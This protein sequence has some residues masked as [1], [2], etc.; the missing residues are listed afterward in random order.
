MSKQSEGQDSYVPLDGEEAKPAKPASDYQEIVRNVRDFQSKA[1]ATYTVWEACSRI[2]NGEKAA[3]ST[4]SQVNYNVA[5]PT[6]PTSAQQ[7]MFNKLLE[8]FRTLHAKLGVN[9][10]YAGAMPATDAPDDVA[11]AQAAEALL[12]Y[13]MQQQKFDRKLNTGLAWLL[14]TGNVGL[15]LCQYGTETRLEIV[16]PF[17][18]FY[19]SNLS[20]PDDTRW[21]VIRRFAT[22]RELIEMFPQHKAQIIDIPVSIDPIAMPAG[23]SYPST[24]YANN[25]PGDRI[26]YWEYIG[27]DGE[28]CYLLP[29][30]CLVLFQST[31]PDDCWPFA[32]IRYTAI[33]GRMWG[34][35]VIEPSIEPQ[36]FYNL[37]RT[38]TLRNATLCGNP[39][40][41]VH[42][43]DAQT[44]SDWTDRPG[45]VIRWGGDADLAVPAPAYLTP[46]SIPA[47][48]QNLPTEMMSE[49]LDAMGVHAT[50]L[51]KRQAGMTSGRAIEALTENDASQLA[52][53]MQNIE[54]AVQHIGHCALVMMKAYMPEKTMIR[55][56][57]RW[58]APVFKE[59]K[60][61]DLGEET[62]EIFIDADTLFRTRV[63]DR[64]AQVLQDMQMGLVSPEEA[65]DM[66]RARVARMPDLTYMGDLRHA[67][68][69]LESVVALKAPA[70]FY[71]KDNLQLMERVFGEFMKSP[72]YYQLDP[73]TQQLVSDQ[74]DSITA[75]MNPSAQ[76][77][78][79]FPRGS[80]AEPATAIAPDPELVETEGAVDGMDATAPA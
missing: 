67:R 20:D 61:T 71:K 3:V 76:P 74:Y 60:M 1:S 55:Q 70:R 25:Q 65:K 42:N 63:A 4:P 36:R 53:T 40:V 39:K 45:Q 19:E 41:L 17:N 75:L 11:K 21:V 44:A 52:V 32:H 35:G 64:R 29:D 26:E 6:D 38:A 22:K 56:L 77:P 7:A 78:P 24:G 28:F 9:I 57:D 12:A 31:M 8:P 80:A 66:L 58:G 46:P 5:L 13:W 73:D 37:I 48:V 30:P 33:A 54:F 23:G 69:V 50:S 16:S 49:I 10:P 14:Q 34:K 79:V 18:F 62:P 43:S 27:K 72:A 51:G 15:Y 59:L 47:Y 68:E 2:L